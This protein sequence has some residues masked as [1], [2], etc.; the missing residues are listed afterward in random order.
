MKK[1]KLAA[2]KAKL[3]AAP[4]RQGA[5]AEV[6]TAAEVLRNAVLEQ[7][8]AAY[9]P[10]AQDH[11]TAWLNLP[12]VRAALHVNDAA[13]DKNVW[14]ACSN[15]V[16]YFPPVGGVVKLY[17]N[18]FNAT[19]WDIMIFSG[20]SDSIVNMMQTQW[21]IK[22]EMKRPLASKVYT[23]W[24]YPYV[25]NATETQLGGWYL[26]YDRFAWAGVRDAGHMVAQYNPPPAL[27][28]FRSFITTGKPGRR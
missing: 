6:R 4:R 10:C 1:A 17:E 15:T 2:A 9:G 21:I 11:I 27:E 13:E 14:A 23:A 5:A 20:L 3:V 8:P 12:E 24:T 18:F 16:Q 26:Q 7:P 25:W 19:T 28:L 22:E